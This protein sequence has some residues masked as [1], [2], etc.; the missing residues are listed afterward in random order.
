MKKIIIFLLFFSFRCFSQG[1]EIIQLT[2]DEF[3]FYKELRMKSVKEFPE[4]FGS[5]YD[6]E[7]LLC[8][9]GW[10]RRLKLNMLFAKSDDKIVGMIGAKIDSRKKLKHSALIISFYVL[11]EFRGRKVGFLLISTLIEKLR[12]ERNIKRFILH[13]TT[14]AMSAIRLYKKLGFKVVGTLPDEYCIDN[15]YYDQYLMVL[16]M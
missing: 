10:Q 12:S 13:V 14:T 11:P 8:D 6:E 3:L 16:T 15:K 9:E 7:L 2:P 1:I 4:A 5:T